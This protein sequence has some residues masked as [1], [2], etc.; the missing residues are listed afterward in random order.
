MIDNIMLV[1]TG[2]LNNRDTNEVTRVH[3]V[4]DKYTPVVCDKR[5]CSLSCLQVQL[6]NRTHAACCTLLADSWCSRSD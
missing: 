6:A 1:L 5:I 4:C 2:T 3:A